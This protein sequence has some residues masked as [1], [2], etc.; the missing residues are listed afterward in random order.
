[1]D[2][3]FYEIE[4]YFSVIYK[5]ETYDKD[6]IFILRRLR[7]TIIIDVI[8]STM[9]VIIMTTVVVTTIRQIPAVMRETMADIVSRV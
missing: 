9:D 5:K 3:L 4:C 1:M 6:G 7:C 8:F 2:L